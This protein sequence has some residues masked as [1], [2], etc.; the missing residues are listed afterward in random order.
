MFKFFFVK[1]RFRFVYILI[2][3]AA[4]L[5]TNILFKENNKLY[6]YYNTQAKI[7]VYNL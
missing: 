2:T 4:D 7:L 1:G 5:G 3:Y 6:N